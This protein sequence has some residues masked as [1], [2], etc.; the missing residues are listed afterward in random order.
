MSCEKYIEI[1]KVCFEKHNELNPESQLKDLE[2]F[3]SGF[4]SCL[5]GV[6][7]ELFN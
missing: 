2:A 4:M 7:N 6:F 1:A 3:V 5:G